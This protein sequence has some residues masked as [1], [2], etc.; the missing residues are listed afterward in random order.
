MKL[1]TLF[2]LTLVFLILPSE[3]AFGAP[4][5][6]FMTAG[7]GT[8]GALPSGVTA[9]ASGINLTVA[10]AT[11]GFYRVFDSNTTPGDLGVISFT[12]STA[13]ITVLI[14]DSSATNIDP[15]GSLAGAGCRDLGGFAPGGCQVTLQARISRNLVSN[16][17]VQ[18][19][20]IVR[21]DVDGTMT[22]PRIYHDSTTE[23]LFAISVGGQIADDLNADPVV[24]EIRSRGG[25]I[26][27]V[28]CN[29]A[30][31]TPGPTRG[32]LAVRVRV[33][34]TSN[35]ASGDI[36]FIE[37]NGFDVGGARPGNDRPPDYQA[38][39]IKART[40]DAIFG[41]SIRSNIVATVGI[42]H[43]ESSVMGIRGNLTTPTL[44]PRGSNI[45]G[46]IKSRGGCDMNM[47]FTQELPADGK[48]EF[49]TYYGYPCGSFADQPKIKIPSEGLKGQIVVNSLIAQFPIS[50]G[51]SVPPTNVTKPLFASVEVGSGTNTIVITEPDYP[52]TP[53]QLGGGCVAVAPFRLHLND[54]MPGYGQVGRY[55]GP[56]ESAFTAAAVPVLICSYGPV[57]LATGVTD[58]NQAVRIDCRSE[59]TCDWMLD[60]GEMFDVVLH[61][62]QAGGAQARLRAI[63]LKRRG[64]S[65]PKAGIYRVVPLNLQCDALDPSAPVATGATRDVNWLADCDDEPAYVF[66]IGPDCDLHGQANVND[67]FEIDQSRNS[68]TGIS[69][70]DLNDNDSIDACDATNAC[71]CDWNHN[72]TVT[73]QDIFDFLADYFNNNGDFNQ[74]GSTSVQDIFDFLTCYFSAPSWC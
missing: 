3:T 34:D 7:G 5:V 52:Q 67:L 20:R 56:L 1:S 66:R 9:T 58:P 53:S 42:R 36:G 57:R 19:N 10:D 72:H 51:C 29:V 24:S 13:T 47:T 27:R 8:W 50:I 22:N 46:L 45:G 70:L 65:P 30:T 62:S 14:A 21:L 44:L 32:P 26:E 17:I 43:L 41:A 38:T 68:T 63:G 74:S 23:T 12:N 49:A 60:M 40:I 39:E 71:A 64:D 25:R 69:P 18:A 73:V 28:A 33:L 48:V 59:N 35:N 37:A 31:T 61:P 2:A 4:S 6:Q 15:D 55:E 11:G 16:A 54:S